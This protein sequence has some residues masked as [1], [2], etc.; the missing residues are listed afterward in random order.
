MG[1]QHYRNPRVGA[2][3]HTAGARDEKFISRRI[4]QIA[5]SVFSWKKKQ[6]QRH[7]LRETPAKGT[8]Y[9]LFMFRGVR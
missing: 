5:L 2:V 8:K 1:T 4:F 9:F 7:P 3:G 6:E